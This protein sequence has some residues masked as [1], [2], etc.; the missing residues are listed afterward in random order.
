MPNQQDSQQ[1]I[2]PSTVYEVPGSPDQYR[3]V[4]RGA[5][6]V[7]IDEN[8]QEQVFMFVGNIMSLD[9]SVNMNFADGQT[10]NSQDLF[11][12]SEMEDMELLD[13]ESTEWEVESQFSNPVE[14]ED[15]EGNTEDGQGLLPPAEQ[16]DEVPAQA[17]GG[18]PKDPT[19]ELMEMQR[20]LITEMSEKGGEDGDLSSD[21]GMDSSSSS[22]ES[23]E[24]ASDP[25]TDTD[26]EEDDGDGDGPTE[27]NGTG[28]TS[29]DSPTIKL[30]EA[31]DS[32]LKEGYTT[33]NQQPSF[34][35]TSAP[36]ST[37]EIWVDGN[38]A[39]SVTA[40]GNG[41][42]TSEAI[43]NLN[44]GEHLLYA[45]TVYSGG[46][47]FQSTVHELN[48]D[49]VAPDL[50]SLELSASSNT[51]TVLDG[52][53]YTSD[54]TPTLHGT[55]GDPNSTV[56]LAVSLNG[57]AYT[58]LSSIDVGSDGS[59]SYTLTSDQ[60]LAD[61]DYTFRVTSTDDAGNAA[62]G[63]TFLDDVV[64]KT[65]AP[66]SSLSLSAASDSMDEDA[67]GTPGDRLTNADTLELVADAS[68]DTT[69]VEIFLIGN[70]TY[71][72]LG[73]AAK[74]GDDWVFTVQNADIPTDGTYRF[75]A[76]A[77]DV[78]GNVEVI[79]SKFGLEV[80]IDR[81][82]E[83]VAPQFDD[84]DPASDT[85]DAAGLL[86]TDDDGYTNANDLTLNGS[87]GV[88]VPVDIY[89]S[90]D[91]G[92]R[93]LISDGEITTDNMGD[94]TY[95][96]D[97]SAYG[98]DGA[99]NLVFTAEVLDAAAN[100]TSTTLSVDVD[101]T[102]PDR[103]TIG[104]VDALG[105]VES[106]V[107]EVVATVRNDTA[108]L[109]GVV[110]ES[111]DD[112]I[113]TVYAVNGG[114]RTA[115]ADNVAG[116]AAGT[117]TMVDNGNGTYTWSYDYGGLNDGQS[118]A[119][120]VNVE[121]KAG[122]VSSYSKT[123]TIHADRTINA[124][125]IDLDPAQ[126]TTGG[127]DG[128]AGD[129]Y[130]TFE[131]DNPAN[132]FDLQVSGDDNS[133]ISVYLLDASAPGAA[134]IVV[135]G[136]TIGT[137]VLVE[138]V[139]QDVN[140]SWPSVSFDASSYAGTT[141]ALD[142]VAV[143][144]DK[145]GNQAYTDYSFT[146]DDVDPSGGPIDLAQD[147]DFGI[148]N[149]DNIT[150]ARE[151]VLT[152]TLTEGADAVKVTVFDNGVEL[153]EATVSG[154][155]WTYIIGDEGSAD[156]ADY[157]G[158]GGHSYT[159]VIE[160][161]AGN[162]TTLSALEVTIDRSISDPTFE[163]TSG[164]GSSD[165]GRITDD[166]VTNADTLVFNGTSDAH[167]IV[168]VHRVLNGVDTVIDT[169]EAGS[170]SWTRPVDNTYITADGDYSF[171]ITTTD[172]A[173]NTNTSQASAVA[174]TIDR[175]T[176]TPSAPELDSGSDSYYEDGAFTA[177]TSD[178]DQITNAE[179]LTI[180]G[181]VEAGGVEADS[182]VNLYIDG[183]ND[184]NGDPKVI[185]STTVG[186][187][188][189]T[190]S[191]P[192]LNS[193]IVADGDYDFYVRY[194]DLAGNESDPSGDLTVAID[195]DVP[196]Q[197]TITMDGSDGTEFHIHGGDYYTNDVTPTFTLSGLEV[198]TTL[199]VKVDGTAV[200]TIAVT[201]DTMAFAPS[202]FATT[203]ADGTVHTI[204]VVAVDSAGNDSPEAEFS[205]TLDTTADPISG[206][207]LTTA[208]DS[209]ESS[210][211]DYTNITTPTIEG[212]A[213][214]NASVT[215]VLKDSSDN[216]VFTD[217][218]VVADA[219][220]NWTATVTDGNALVDG[221][222][223]T[224]EVTATDYAGNQ[225][226]DTSYTFELDTSIQAV[227]LHMVETAANDTGEA[228]DDQYT[229]NRAP[230][231]AWT[232]GEDL[233]A[234]ISLYNDSNVLLDAYTVD[235][236]AG[237]NDWTVPFNLGDGDYTVTA[238][239]VDQAGNTVLTDG[240]VE[241]TE[242]VD[243]TIDHSISK[244]TFELYTTGVNDSDTGRVDD[245]GVTN[246][247]DL[248]FHGTS[249]VGDTVTV[250]RGS[251]VVGTFEALST[252][253]DFTVPQAN[254]PEGTFNFYVTTEDQA[255]NSDSST[256]VAVTIDRSYNTPGD[257]DLDSDSDS[258]YV[259]GSF[260]ANTTNSDNVTSATGLIFTGDVEAGG[261]EANSVVY[262][263]IDGQADPVEET[264]VG[265]LGST[266][267]IT[268]D[269]SGL[270]NGSYNF[271]VKYVD[272]AGNE[273]G[274]SQ[275]LPVTI[276]RMDPPDP[277][278][279]IDGSEGT[280]YFID[281]GDYYVK[282]VDPTF[283]LSN[284]EVDTYLNIKMDG[285][286]V[287][288]VLVDN[289][290]M[291][292]DPA[293]FASDGT[294]DG[295]HTITVVA[296]DSAGNDSQEI[297]FTFNLDTVA[298]GIS[299][300]KLTDETNSGA[301][302][303]AIT[304]VTVPVVTGL[305]EAEATIEVE[306]FDGATSV[307]TTTVTANPNGRWNAEISDVNGDPVL[308][309][310]ATYSV[311]VTATDQA[312][313]VS[314]D[315]SYSFTLDT[316][317]NEV[318][319]HMV[320]D[321]ANDT[322]FTDDDQYTKN[323]NPEFEW[324]CDED[325]TVTISIY[326][327]NDDLMNSYTEAS[328][329][330]TNT[331]MVPGGAPLTDGDYTV[332][333]TFTDTAGNVLSQDING[334]PIESV[335]LT[336]DTVPP[337]LT[338]GLTDGSDSGAKGDWLTNDEAV[339]AGLHLTGDGE[340]L[341]RVYVYVN[342]MSN[343]ITDPGSG[344]DYLTV[345]GDTWDFDLSALDIGSGLNAG[346]NSIM[347]VAEDQAGNKTVFTH[348]LEIDSEVIP[349]GHILLDDD[350]NSGFKSDFITNETEPLLYGVTEGNSTVVLTVE[351][352]GGV[353]TS[354]ATLT[355]DNAGNWSV[356]V[357]KGILTADGNYTF[358]A[359]I[360]D[361][362]GNQATTSQ[363]LTIDTDLAAPTL[364]MDVDSYGTFNGTDSDFITDDTTPEFTITTEVDTGLQ[365]YRN[366]VLIHTVDIGDNDV[367][368]VLTYT[369]SELGEGTY[370][371]RFV[372][373]DSAGN[374]S[375]TTQVVEIDPTYEAADL[376]VAL[377][378][379]YDSG[380]SDSDGL[381]NEPRP[382]FSGTAEAGSKVRVYFS[383]RYDTEAEAQA[384]AT[385]V[386]YETEMTLASGDTEWEY[387]PSALADDGS[388]DGFYKVTVVSE[389]AAG[390]QQTTTTVMELDTQAPSPTPT[391]ELTEDGGN[392]IVSATQT[393]DNTPGFAGTAEPGS[394]VSITVKAFGSANAALVAEAT[395]DVNGDWFYQ[396]ENAESL[397]DGSYNVSI[398]NTDD[399]G[400]VSEGLAEFQIT[401]DTPV[402]PTIG[403]DAADDTN[404]D[405]D[406]VTGQ[407]T[408]LTLTGIAQ[409][410]A[411]VDLY[412]TTVDDTDCE[413]GT[414]V[415][416]V[417]AGGNGIW[418]ADI[419]G[420]VADG[421]YYYYV[422]SEYSPGNVYTSTLYTMEVDSE[423]ITP[424]LELLDDTGVVDEWLD[425][426]PNTTDGDW[427]SSNATITGTV[428]EGATVVITATNTAT[429]AVETI[430]INP[431]N[432]T[433]TGDEWTY[434]HDLSGLGDGEFDVQVTTTDLAGNTASSAVQT[435]YFDSQTVKPTVDLPDAQDTELSV[436]GDGHIL[437]TNGDPAG[438]AMESHLPAGFVSTIA[439]GY[440]QEDH[441]VLS[442]TAEPG[443]LVRITI[444]QDGNDFPSPEVFVAE[445]DG[446]WTYDTGVL[447]DA[448]YTFEVTT[449]DMAGNEMNAD[450]LNVYVD[451]DATRNPAIALHDGIDN[452]NDTPDTTPTF[453]LYGDS[454]SV[455]MLY[456]DDQADPI[457]T[458]TFNEATSNRSITPGVTAGV[459]MLEA[460]VEHTFVLVTVDR[461][462][463]AA[464]SGQ[465]N[466]EIDT[467]APVQ[468]ADPVGVTG[469]SNI[470]PADGSDP[471]EIYTDDND[472]TITIQVEAGTQAR[473]TGFGDGEWVT[474]TDNDG[475][476]T[477]TVPANSI[478]NDGSHSVTV[479]FRDAAHNHDANED[480]EFNLVVDS[481]RPATT[482]EL[483]Q[484]S[485]LGFSDSDAVTSGDQL[486][487][488]G[489]ILELGLGQE[490]GD[491]A[492]DI[493]DYS[494]TVTN[495]TTNVSETIASDDIT[496]NGDGTW[497]LTYGVDGTPLESGHYQATVTASDMAG[498]E[499]S[500][501][502]EFDVVNDTLNT[503][504]PSLMALGNTGYYLLSQ[505][506][507]VFPGGADHTDYKYEMTFYGKDGD[508]NDISLSMGEQSFNNSGG[509][510]E[511]INPTLHDTYD[512]VG[513]KVIDY[514]G[515]ESEASFTDVD[516]TDVDFSA[517]VDTS[518]DVASLAVSIT[519]DTD[520][521][522][523]DD[524]NL[525]ATPVNVDGDGNWTWD[526]AGTLAEG[527]YTLHFEGF[528]GADGTGNSV[529]GEFTYDFSVLADEMNLASDS[530]DFSAGEADMGDSG[531][532]GGGGGGGDT[533]E[534]DAT[535]HVD[536]VE[537]SV[538]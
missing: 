293:D 196:D 71:I 153:G 159:A 214:A 355:A 507:Y 263:Y 42:F 462:G 431:E 531:G 150:N 152:G 426:A 308:P 290:S 425:P 91:G 240:G 358:T 397:A 330:G 202:A 438:P 15:A 391:F 282:E 451:A 538:S 179:T 326:D 530:Q 47:E 489:D 432:L 467:I 7:L 61:G 336:V 487:L 57:G 395:A 25:D 505:S 415:S 223:Y 412:V 268:F 89:L 284:L 516:T 88:N 51:S 352:E 383:D 138:S 101:H 534:I 33:N 73:Q 28:N 242:S 353:V 446:T 66:T 238:T 399:A 112:V 366:D 473:M 388:A 533:V 492:T 104:M 527:D 35:G 469:T 178:A 528:E 455:W 523:V 319:F 248:V 218:T 411:D 3:F 347:V 147:D 249:D 21:L 262:L 64:V 185:G 13:H 524:V 499:H 480:L 227:D 491:F 97:V 368:G 244:P 116:G 496:L 102:D 346:D 22:P 402:A 136:V 86:G 186:A 123:L 410:Y 305:A 384:S 337:A 191:I 169:F 481:S 445:A 372:S 456:L 398:T 277:V 161:N 369:E 107:S 134:A 324:T 386:D 298:E 181:D 58:T 92:D 164:I 289:G 275:T 204:T 84:L 221:E 165:T 243:F 24:N 390:N 464:V 448:M 265:S 163:L 175:T 200:Q 437:L 376:T 94:W 250:Y 297:S 406:G 420:T 255:G 155:G 90:V 148:L 75:V 497:T 356:T 48:I 304:N 157:I 63:Y 382:V 216:V 210:T 374:T 400:N 46:E 460:N 341:S 408:N 321:A 450:S 193:D 525:T 472:P 377:H 105:T 301:D 479:E 364:T 187:E 4:L 215:V 118:Y 76:Q 146:L 488:S 335:S 291:T 207:Q 43:F 468:Q 154:G 325:L 160:D 300:V 521:D 20:K 258:Y 357:P 370:T 247:T 36:G 117:V 168:S 537:G 288:T 142:F 280:D 119:F 286:S 434:H 192:V 458:G 276:D 466:F 381:T 177:G 361:E 49:I 278:I 418:S 219:S 106:D 392:T 380:V 132:A 474:D 452:T 345:S 440:T 413:N 333:A 212:T 143:T 519:G 274:A 295:E 371:Y 81:T 311:H 510:E 529:G 403:L 512:Y 62:T 40:D 133:T 449:T 224:V 256:P 230:Q 226:T 232:A 72:S 435:M 343:S 287:Q 385:G 85:T 271:Y 344:N 433:K 409:S 108:T 39:D 517:T 508:G 312:N 12:R 373:T 189:T 494:V 486:V 239:F 14:P 253:W 83:P 60:A 281:N 31:T 379:D 351:N 360:T 266:W 350:S 87:A 285:A 511:V 405:T 447:D 246:A 483:D 174:V 495:T 137:G 340:N 172:V 359:V 241:V 424:T 79:Q 422:S 45:K 151:I 203:D 513:I 98:T 484:A 490:I 439:D 257:I 44:G 16:N 50:P 367:N 283:T 459:D 306:I 183:V 17:E 233:T 465:F 328:P 331:W 8:N 217:N 182:V 208:S 170:D 37:V 206:V 482:I 6:L 124:P 394:T 95:S 145:A 470:V 294:D 502:T 115:I 231:F 536:Y 348:T 506:D 209:G 342:D 365:I 93:V 436:D 393:T 252:S 236:P 254:A 229:G 485:N 532:G 228:D 338:V 59:W 362:A 190:W 122:N 267:S 477:F 10:L 131:N 110:T 184:I 443:A 475:V 158:E 471:M 141:T 235:S 498:N 514:A 261:V 441:L 419:S 197:P 332:T 176:D 52:N 34:E 314:T 55:G 195:R 302:D 99:Q 173:G 114:T 461:A 315:D 378:S 292:F 245:D 111:G 421:T 349:V 493:D 220:G 11:T 162:Q 70:G 180:T 428:D 515:N 222:T 9:G 318:D 526:F 67:G 303:D 156:P 389:D 80:E 503:P 354:V 125:S 260:T 442:G 140:D 100:V 68:D 251:T 139:T 18:A 404:I 414:L 26:T 237:A 407:N 396:V 166:G 478:V 54:T 269:A 65:D 109:E 313:N 121:D 327:E 69:G 500:S 149:T 144:E 279:E 129:D 375:Q 463:N 429:S 103:P 509:I 199:N 77:T 41:H 56:T 38:M 522:N 296:V 307:F 329:A 363:V 272:L 128:V 323:R 401:G 78:A 27:Y 194:V 74:S 299:G 259:D 127:P 171:Y 535:V 1:R 444:L 309:G 19:D 310:D 518:A 2:A 273:S 317:I 316:T 264:P 30:T 23:N 334:D 322:G 416:T 120:E 234:T 198:D 113:V 427:E 270:T 320:E 82:P 53:L 5:D 130:T 454:D 504:E 520:G 457:A 430:T 32:G 501:T 135:N 188:G 225:D 29:A 423:T 417:E 167:D 387:S 201:S 339:T 96:Y 205:F 211:D 213:E 476:I 453:T 126:D